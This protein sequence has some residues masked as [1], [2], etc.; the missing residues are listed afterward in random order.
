MGRLKEKIFGKK[1]RQP[2]G[3]TTAEAAKP[4]IFALTGID[5]SGSG[6][7]A[8]NAPRNRRPGRVTADTPL[9]PK[10]AGM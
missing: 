6:S 4:G 9:G 10:R 8:P 1:K 7:N 5:P 3:A 2:K